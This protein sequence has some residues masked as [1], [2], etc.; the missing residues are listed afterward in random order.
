MKNESHRFYQATTRTPIKSGQNTINVEIG[1]LNSTT[2][3]E[4][5]RKII[6]DTFIKV[7]VVWGKVYNYKIGAS[8]N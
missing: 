6:G 3:P 1:P 2:A 4:E 5:K 8:K 7:S